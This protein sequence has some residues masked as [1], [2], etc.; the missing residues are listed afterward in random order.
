M[1]EQARTCDAEL[2]NFAGCETAFGVGRL[3]S[4]SRNVS[5]ASL[6]LSCA[7]LAMVS[8]TAMRW[9]GLSFGVY[10]TRLHRV[11]CAAS[12][13]ERITG[14]FAIR[15]GQAIKTTLQSLCTVVAVVGK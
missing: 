4:E 10:G 11:V 2:S 3:L 15:G 14:R 1:G 5:H 6:W 8:G 7:R 9:L 12:W 13:R